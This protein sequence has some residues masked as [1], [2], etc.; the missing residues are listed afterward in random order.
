MKLNDTVMKGYL[1]IYKD[2]GTHK[3]FVLKDDPN[4]ITMDSRRVHLQYLYDHANAPVD[5]LATFQIGSGGAIGDD[6]Q[7]NNNVIVIPPDPTRS[8]L[9]SQ[10]ALPED[11]ITIL[12]SDANDNSRVYLQ[13]IFSVSQDRANGNKINECG[14]FKESGLMFNHKTFSSIEKSEAFSLVFDWKL[15]YT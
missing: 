8:E 1:S 5:Q 12:P 14:L 2:F 15:V 9:Y 7:G 10:I 3:E 11:S 4:T 13:I 6:T